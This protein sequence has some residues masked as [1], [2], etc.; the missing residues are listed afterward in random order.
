M[1]NEVKGKGKALKSWREQGSLRYFECSHM[2]QFISISDD[3]VDPDFLGRWVSFCEYKIP[4]IFFAVLIRV[5]V[6]RK[7]FGAA[8][9]LGHTCHPGTLRCVDGR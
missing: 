7:P 4:R 3:P 6:V 8:C 1:K 2:I 5:G 9:R